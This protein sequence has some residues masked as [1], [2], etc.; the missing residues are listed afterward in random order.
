MPYYLK[1]SQNFN[2]MNGQISPKDAL[3]N[4][5][6]NEA[7]PKDTQWDNIPFNELVEEIGNNLMNVG[8][9]DFAEELNSKVHSAVLR[10]LPK[11][12]QEILE[13]NNILA[14]FINSVIEAEPDIFKRL[15]DEIS[16][17]FDENH[18]FYMP[19]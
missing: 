5:V 8:H 2:K 6:P 1:K 17:I 18:Q 16:L 12:S 14:D 13:D 7:K 10:I 9:N 11:D 15:K 4:Q 3:M 19:Q